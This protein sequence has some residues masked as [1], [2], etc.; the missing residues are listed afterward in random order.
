[1]AEKDIN[2]LKHLFLYVKICLKLLIIDS[3]YTNTP[4]FVGKLQLYVMS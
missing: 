2:L 4:L 1:M 3:F